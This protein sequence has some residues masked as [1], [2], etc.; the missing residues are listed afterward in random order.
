MS[1]LNL[2]KSTLYTTCF[3][4]HWSSTG[5]LKLFVDTAALAFCASNVR[6]VVPSD[7]RVFRRAGCFLLLCCVF[8]LCSW[9]TWTR[10]I[11]R[12][13][14]VSCKFSGTVWKT[15]FGDSSSRHKNFAATFHANRKFNSRTRHNGR[16]VP[17]E[18][19]QELSNTLTQ[20]FWTI[21]IF[22]LYL[23]NTSIHPQSRRNDVLLCF[24][25]LVAFR[26]STKNYIL[27]FYKPRNL[28]HNGKMTLEWWA[29]SAATWVDNAGRA[30]KSTLAY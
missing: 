15:F 20:S 18:T 26:C 30:H 7:I 6:C 28:G 11:R 24:L 22:F 4:R 14:K 21:R 1:L 5:V 12:T 8:R 19:Y 25:I 10:D 3:D 16:H 29:S 23:K 9:F 13:D 17:K 2:F 27:T